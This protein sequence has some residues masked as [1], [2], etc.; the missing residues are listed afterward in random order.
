[1]TLLRGVVTHMQ[2]LILSL[3]PVSKGTGYVA[4][5]QELHQ[6]FFMKEL[7]HLRWRRL[8]RIQALHKA[9]NPQKYP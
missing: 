5:G 7:T 6:H 8:T 9:A 1:M 4:V 2:L 3:T